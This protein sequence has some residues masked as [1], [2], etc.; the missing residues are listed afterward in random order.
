MENISVPITLDAFTLC[1][2]SC[3]A[4]ADVKIAPITQPSY[5]GLRLDSSIIQH[6]V[7]PTVDLH[8][9]SPPEANPRVAD[10][11]VTPPEF[12]YNRCG[13]YLH[14]SLP[15][16]YRTGSAAAKDTTNEDGK[17]IT[18]A[19]PAFRRVPNRWLVVRRLKYSEP[20]IPLGYTSW[21][22]ESD[23]LRMIGELGPEVD[24]EVD[25]TPFVAHDKKTINDEPLKTQV[26]SALPISVPSTDS[27]CRQ[28]FSLELAFP[29]QG[30]RKAAMANM[31]R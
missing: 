20:A 25:V 2:D 26:G 14:W 1:P 7:L 6:D 22:V 11:G 31:C 21:V 10:V 29:L 30:T 3:A 23:R 5:V 9:T 16:L 19:N 4:E 13:V 27:W 28:R 15:R 12:K 18:N 24:L 8:N 17:D